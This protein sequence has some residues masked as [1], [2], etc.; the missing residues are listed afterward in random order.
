MMT[1]ATVDA[2]G[3]LDWVRSGTHA[4]VGVLDVGGV[5]ENARGHDED[6]LAGLTRPGA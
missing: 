2:I 5:L 1:L 6:H 3:P 4:T